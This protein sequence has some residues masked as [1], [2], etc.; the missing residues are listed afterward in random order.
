MDKA[1]LYYKCIRSHFYLVPTL[2]VAVS[3]LTT[4]VLDVSPYNTFS[5]T[6]TTSSSVNGVLTPFSKSIHWMRS[7]ESGQTVEIS[8]STSGVTVTHID[9]DQAT[10]TSVISIITS[11]AGRHVYICEVLLEVLNSEID[12]GAV[13]DS[14]SVSVQG[15]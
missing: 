14:F 2:S 12:N 1:S 7:I 5:L 9:Q 3:D 15:M 11:T 8:N 6:C 13:Q 4:R 10:S